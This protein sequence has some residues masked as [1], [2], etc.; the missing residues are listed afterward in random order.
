VKIRTV[1]YRRLVTHGEYQNTAIGAVA[2]VEGDPAAEL[3]AL[4]D[5]VEGQVKVHIALKD[6][7]YQL[8]NS[9]NNLRWTV[10]DYERQLEVA[11]ARWE[12]AKAILA[13]HGVELP[14]EPT[15]YDSG[16]D[17]MPF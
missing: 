7:T 16:L 1:E 5:W 11:K 13:A 15:E 4:K 14:K 9:A 10:Q 2:E 8:Q 3:E 17:G 6:E 12:A